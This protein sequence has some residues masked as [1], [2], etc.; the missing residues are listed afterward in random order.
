MVYR[1]EGRGSKTAELLS[2]KD[3]ELLETWGVIVYPVQGYA[4]F[5]VFF[6][7]CD[8]SLT[9]LHSENNDK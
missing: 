1:R 7:Y 9:N 5:G 2:S 6:F 4:T 3:N 8:N